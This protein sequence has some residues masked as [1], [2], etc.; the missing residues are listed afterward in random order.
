MV[1]LGVLMFVFKDYRLL[2]IRD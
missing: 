2:T 1:V